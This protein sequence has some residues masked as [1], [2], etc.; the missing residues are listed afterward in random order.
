MS[1]VQVTAWVDPDD[2]M[3]ELDSADLAEELQTRADR[4]D[5]IAKRCLLNFGQLPT[6]ERAEDLIKEIEET[7]ASGDRI[8]FGVLMCRLRAMVLTAPPVQSGTTALKVA[9]A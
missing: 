6:I 3:D 9:F 8:H 1:R 4:G 2:L 7:A 5:K